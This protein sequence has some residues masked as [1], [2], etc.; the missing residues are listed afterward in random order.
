MPD[1]GRA[2][3]DLSKKNNNQ[4]EVLN[5]LQATI[6][7]FPKLTG[8][9]D[10][11]MRFKRITSYAK[12]V[13]FKTIIL[14]DGVYEVSDTIYGAIEND[15]LA[16]KF[17]GVNAETVT[18]IA[19][20]TGTT[21]LFAFE[22]IKNNIEGWDERW[23]N[24]GVQ[25]IRI[26]PKVVGQGVGIY[27][28]GGCFNQFDNVRITSMK[29]GVRLHNDKKGIYTE[30]NTFTRMRIDFCDNAFRLERNEVLDGNGN[31]LE[32]D[33]NTGDQSFRGNIFDAQINVKPN[34]RGL[35][36]GKGCVLYNA[37]LRLYMWG[38][39]NTDGTQPTGNSRPVYIYCDGTVKTTDGLIAVESY[40]ESV[41][42]GTGSFIFDGKIKGIA[43]NN[44]PN[45][46]V[47]DTAIQS[48]GH[49]VYQTENKFYHNERRA[50]LANAGVNQPITSLKGIS[51]P[52]QTYRVFLRVY[53]TGVDVRREYVCNANG[54]GIT[55]GYVILD[56]EYVNTKTATA[57]VS[58]SP[59]VD[60]NGKFAINVQT[61]VPL[62]WVLRAES[63]GT[64][65]SNW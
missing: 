56:K 42:S 46:I 31:V 52:N 23:S 39:K 8:E 22:K 19:N 40:A 47:D 53:G 21:P 29:Y 30:L 1:Y 51:D 63:L 16:V 54:D 15:K 24:G 11:T 26:L 58:T 55:N 64:S 57:F 43:G 5:K 36:V 61:D 60:K 13:G 45:V 4:I 38:Q 14:T 37:S 33:P 59:W 6:D 44:Q 65:I 2:A 35:S 50:I 12:S 10:D 25:D 20:L 28:R 48:D 62:T 41:L 9:N 49:R 32:S 18:I 17:K 27:V 3:F 34:Q 7:S